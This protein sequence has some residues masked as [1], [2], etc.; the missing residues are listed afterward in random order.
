MTDKSSDPD[1]VSKRGAR[2]KRRM[3]RK[4]GSDANS[5]DESAPKLTR[6]ERLAAKGPRPG[7]GKGKTKGKRAESTKEA[8]PSQPGLDAGDSAA[9][10]SDGYIDRHKLPPILPHQKA[11]RTGKG[12]AAAASRHEARD[13]IDRKYEGADESEE[14]ED[15]TG[16]SDMAD[17][18]AASSAATGAGEGSASTGA[19]GVNVDTATVDF[20][21][22]DS[23]LAEYSL[24]RGFGTAR[25][26]Y[27]NKH[28]VLVFSSRGLTM[29]YRH[30]LDDLR[31]MLP[32]HKKESKLDA[33]D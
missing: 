32:H 31:A 12:A 5:I 2:K 7:K 20:K 18:V 28:R 14:E 11:Y 33:K 26:P 17:S 19:G 13:A 3:D 1:H 30:L 22:V 8:K 29:R 15:E 6:E 27:R 10:S 23:S 9:G 21:Q 24:K 4:D 16:A 25:V